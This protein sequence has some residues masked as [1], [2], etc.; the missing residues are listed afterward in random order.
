V[1]VWEFV[2]CTKD[3]EKGEAKA[4]CCADWVI[5]AR[6]KATLVASVPLS[7]PVKPIFGMLHAVRRLIRKMENA[8][9]GILGFIFPQ[10]D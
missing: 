2:G 6:V 8:R 4:V 9:R 10:Q 5:A 3:G 7:G 1:G